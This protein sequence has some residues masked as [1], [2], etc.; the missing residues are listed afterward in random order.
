LTSED[1]INA[2]EGEIIIL[3]TG[4][5]CVFDFPRE[6]FNKYLKKKLKLINPKVLYY[7]E[8]T[9][10]LGRVR[11]FVDSEKASELKVW[12]TILL[13]ENEEYFLTEIEMP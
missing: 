1:E 13:S 2:S 12:L 4:K 5:G 9:S 11:L 3:N 6:F 8:K 7:G 10:R